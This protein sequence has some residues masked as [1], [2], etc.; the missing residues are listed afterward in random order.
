MTPQQII[1]SSTLEDY[2]PDIWPLRIIASGTN[3][4]TNLEL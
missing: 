2:H 1:S 3:F 4:P